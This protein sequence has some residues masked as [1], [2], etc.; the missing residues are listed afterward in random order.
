MAFDHSSFGRWV[1]PFGGFGLPVGCGVFLG[2]E[3]KGFGV[4]MG[5]DEEEL[6]VGWRGF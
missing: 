4:R 1:E 6:G 3:V 5:T 2:W